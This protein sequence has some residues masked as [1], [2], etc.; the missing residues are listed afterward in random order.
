VS[1]PIHA[2]ALLIALSVAAPAG[3]ALPERPVGVL[4]LY[5]QARILPAVIA[6]DEGLRT[7]LQAGLPHG[8]FFHTEYL[9]ATPLSASAP[10]SLVDVLEEKYRGRPLDLVVA[11]TSLGL[12][13]AERRALRDPGPVSWFRWWWAAYIARGTGAQTPGMMRIEGGGVVYES[14][15][16]KGTM[17]FHESDTGRVW[18]WRG[19]TTDGSTVRHELTKSK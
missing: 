12:R 17:T 3:A 18:E 2:P 19:T 7:E 5:A 13:S 9:D 14:P 8:V 4:L 16:S 11:S 15:T 6:Q 10:A 1:R